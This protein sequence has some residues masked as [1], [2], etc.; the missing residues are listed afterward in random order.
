MFKTRR[1]EKT[2][3]MLKDFEVLKAKKLWSSAIA[4]VDA[5][6]TRCTPCNR[7]KYSHTYAIEMGVMNEPSLQAYQPCPTAQRLYQL[8]RDAI[9]VYRLTGGAL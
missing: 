5:H 8:E 7:K 1:I 3:Q 4:H 6:S 9:Q 2:P